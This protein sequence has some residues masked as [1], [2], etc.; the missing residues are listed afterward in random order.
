MT[1]D[2]LTDL[3]V[4]GLCSGMTSCG[5]TISEV[6]EHNGGGWWGRNHNGSN[7]VLLTD[8]CPGGSHIGDC[9]DCWV[10]KSVCFT[11]PCWNMY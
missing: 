11:G 9:S 7:N 4:G 5:A 2:V 10:N 1:I 3:I 8:G 6:W